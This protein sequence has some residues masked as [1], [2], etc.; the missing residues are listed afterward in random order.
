VDPTASDITA[1]LQIRIGALIFHIFI[2]VSLNFTFIL[3]YGSLILQ[4]TNL[5][6]K[7]SC[8]LRLAGVFQ[9]EYGHY[10]QSRSSGFA[11]LNRYAIPSVRKKNS[12]AINKNDPSDPDYNPV[13]QD[14]IA[15][16]IKYFHKRNKKDFKWDFENN[17]IG[18]PGKGWTMD[19]YDTPRFQNL[20]NSLTIKP[21]ATD[22]LFPIIQGLFNKNYYNNHYIDHQ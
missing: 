8:K 14:A 5:Y 11:Y 13:E 18:Y 19:D 16:S 12:D 2:S 4:R 1:K 3:C 10:L 7:R 21:D 15:R 9:H 6:K 17:P 20:L 22:Y